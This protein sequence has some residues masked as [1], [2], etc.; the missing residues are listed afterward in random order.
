MNGLLGAVEILGALVLLLALSLVL[1]ALRQR[2][3]ARLGGTF[4]CSLRLSASAPSYGWTLGVGRYSQGTL[5]WFR[6]FSYAW[7]PR[8]NLSRE[9]VRVLESREP[10]VV[11]SV[12]LGPDQRVLRVETAL[13]RLTGRELDRRPSGKFDRRAAGELELAMSPESLTGL[14]SWLEAAPPGRVR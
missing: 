13:D 11:E 7:R 14:L 10:D 8:L 5:Q 6:F 9:D 4:S 1:L 3:L 12:S 2:W